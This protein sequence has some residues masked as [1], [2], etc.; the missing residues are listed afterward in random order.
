MNIQNAKLGAPLTNE[1]APDAANVGGPVQTVTKRP[2]F[3]Q[4]TDQDA[5]KIGG[6]L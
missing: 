5:K 2:Y 4:S 1:K 3:K 6:R